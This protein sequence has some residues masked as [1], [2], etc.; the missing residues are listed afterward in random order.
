MS[1]TIGNM[2]NT[3]IAAFLPIFVQEKNKALASSGGFDLKSS[4]IALIIS[5][6]QIA[7]LMLLPFASDVKNKVGNRNAIIGGIF[8]CGICT[9]L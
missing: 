4:D 2:F 6:M 5:A 9:I 8:V 1:K 3:C 7:Q